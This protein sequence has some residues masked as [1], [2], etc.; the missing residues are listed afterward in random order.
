M[1]IYCQ[2]G[3][4]V[5]APVCFSECVIV[6]SEILVENY[7]IDPVKLTGVRKFWA[8][9]HKSLESRRIVEGYPSDSCLGPNP[10]DAEGSQ[11]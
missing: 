7:E 6:C 5:T 8:L 4:V 1:Q 3:A 10:A 2:Y 9:L 11:E